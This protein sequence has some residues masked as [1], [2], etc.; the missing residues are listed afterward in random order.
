M[1]F[2]V[3]KSIFFGMCLSIS[4]LMGESTEAISSQAQKKTN[5]DFL[6]PIITM[7]LDSSESRNTEGEEKIIAYAKNPSN[8]EPTLQDYEKAE[9][10]CVNELNLEL[11]NQAILD[12]GENV[13]SKVM[14]QKISNKVNHMKNIILDNDAF[15][16]DWVIMLATALGMEQNCE[17]NIAGVLLTGRDVN[18]KQGMAY[19]SILH[20]YDRKDIS[21][22]LN[23]RQDMRTYALDVTN[24]NPRH[25]DYRGSFRNI[26]EF[27]SYQCLDYSICVGLNEANNMVCEIL[28]QSD[29]KVTWIV[30]GH[31]H[32]VANIL[33]ETQ[34]CNGQQLVSE[35]VD[36]IVLANGWKSRT[37]G[38][39]EMNFSEGTSKPN[40]ASDASKYFFAHRPPNVPVVIAT[41]PN[42]DMSDKRVADMYR[43]DRFQNSPM[44][45]ILSV[46][47]YGVYGDHGLSDTEALLYGVRGDFAPDGT[48]Y[49]QEIQSCFRIKASG[50]VV[51]GNTSC[52][53][54]E[55]YLEKTTFAYGDIWKQQVEELLYK[56]PKGK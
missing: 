11:M 21:I 37:S 50:A 32:N 29:E 35:K 26:D 15:D 34:V 24:P 8:P 5:T 56:L 48:Q 52:G 53:R 2:I 18:R 17:A 44:A 16:P 30:G 23:V 1:K 27:Q 36:K 14:I 31:L 20:Y 25:V 3:N 12:E 45:F 55:F 46:D 42:I 33:A 38:E 40:S 19:S 9:I 43:A 51:A 41:I 10:K 13:D 22:G 6:I 4:Y 47:R 54:L 39:P 7:L 49:T 28:R